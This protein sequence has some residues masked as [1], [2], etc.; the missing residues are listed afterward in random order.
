MFDKSDRE[1]HN[2]INVREESYILADKI[3]PY[4]LE[5]L[6]EGIKLSFAQLLTSF[7]EI[8]N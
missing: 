6:N 7:Q 1:L 3:R 5:Y 8:S 4:V 2:V